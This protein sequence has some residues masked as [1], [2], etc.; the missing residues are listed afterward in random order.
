LPRSQVTLLTSRYVDHNRR[1]QGWGVSQYLDE[2]SSVTQE[3]LNANVLSNTTAFVGPSICCDREGFYLE[4][5]LN[6]GY[7]N[8]DRS[9]HISLVTAQKYPANNCQLSGV[10]NSQDIFANFLNHTSAQA[11]TNGYANDIATVRAA[12]KDFFM[13][14][15]NTAS[16]GGFPGLSDSFG[17]AMW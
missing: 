7:L 4:D 17:A 5:V 8:E 16:C 1:P 10:T 14:E 2:Y 9:P 15:M 13:M 3:I 11:L 12:G 6:A